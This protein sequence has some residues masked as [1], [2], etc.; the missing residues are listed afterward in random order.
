MQIGFDGKCREPVNWKQDTH[1]AYNEPQ[2]Y[3]LLQFFT[4]FPSVRIPFPLNLSGTAAS[5]Q[6]LTHTF[7]IK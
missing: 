7:L 3:I 5:L 2:E 4:S 1:V 6:K